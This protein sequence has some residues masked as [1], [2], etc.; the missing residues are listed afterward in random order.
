MRGSLQL[1]ELAISGSA[2]P[3]PSPL[4]PLPLGVSESAFFNPPYPGLRRPLGLGARNA[5]RRRGSV[6]DHTGSPHRLKESGTV[7]RAISVGFYGW[8]TRFKSTCIARQDVV[9]Y[10]IFN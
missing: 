4:I 10:P 2:G 5:S 8:A 3:P 6:L 1:R 7:A 9:P